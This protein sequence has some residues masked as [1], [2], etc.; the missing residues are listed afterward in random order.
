MMLDLRLTWTRSP[1]VLVFPLTLIRSSRNCLNASQSNR[2]W[3]T[4]VLQS[5]L[6]TT[7]VTGL[8]FPVPNRAAKEMARRAVTGILIYQE[9]LLFSCPTHKHSS[10]HH[11]Y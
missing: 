4:G 7:R 2:P 1:R 9:K 11:Y 6:Y 8:A 5:I 3:L 10:F